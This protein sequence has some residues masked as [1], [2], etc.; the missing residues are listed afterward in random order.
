MTLRLN[1]ILK[2]KNLAPYGIIAFMNYCVRGVRKLLNRF[3][4]KTLHTKLHKTSQ[5]AIPLACLYLLKI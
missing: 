3:G 1:S 5:E 2:D 4:I